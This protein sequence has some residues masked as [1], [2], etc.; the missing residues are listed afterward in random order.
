[1]LIK[2]KSNALSFKVFFFTLNKEKCYYFFVFA[3]YFLFRNTQKQFFI[4]RLFRIFLTYQPHFI[5]Q[6]AKN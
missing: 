1:M 2:L 5:T 3:N 6:Q 4:N